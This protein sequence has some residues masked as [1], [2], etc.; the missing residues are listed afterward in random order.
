MIASRAGLG[1]LSG[2]ADMKRS[3]AALCLIV[4]FGAVQLTGVPPGSARAKSHPA[5]ICMGYSG[6]ITPSGTRG[7]LTGCSGNTGGSGI[8]FGNATTIFWANSTT[9]SFSFGRRSAQPSKPTS[10]CPAST[11]WVFRTQKGHV[12]AD[13]TGST[14]NGAKVKIP[15]MC[16]WWINQNNNAGFQ[17]AQGGRVKL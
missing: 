15:T 16:E 6:D 3:V 12:T 4:I 11:L 7:S 1:R 14:R 9:T 17:I 10:K 2:G 5:I 8:V 13:T